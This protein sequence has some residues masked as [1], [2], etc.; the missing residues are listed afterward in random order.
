MAELT[1]A[2]IDAEHFVARYAQNRLEGA[3]LEAFEEY[4]LLHPEVAEQV[5]TDRAM[6]DGLHAIEP[7]RSSRWPVYAL[8]ASVA[9]MAVGAV[10]WKMLD[11]W[12]D[13]GGLYAI[14]DTL[15]ASARLSDPL[16]VVRVRDESAQVLAVGAAVSAVSLEIETANTRGAATLDVTLAEERGGEWFERGERKNVAV[17]PARGTVRVV[18]NLEELE[19][20]HWRIQLKGPDKSDDFHVR[21]ERQA[22]TAR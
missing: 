15:P 2:R 22:S 6:R 9:V 20:S 17:D 10:V 19:G 5:Q 11:T 1:R 12:K 7:R 16:R 4:C 3:D 14:T 18:V 13:D 21:V 8:A